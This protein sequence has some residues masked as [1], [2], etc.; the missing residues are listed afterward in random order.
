MI[1]DTHAHIFSWEL[2]GKEDETV[3]KY[4]QAWVKYI[5]CIWYD[6]DSIESTIH[7]AKNHE[8]IHAVIGIHPCD[9]NK[10]YGWI[11]DKIIWLL[12]DTII[13]NPNLIRGI[14]ETWFDYY[15]IDK[16]RFQEEQ[17]IQ[18]DFF[19]AQIALAKKFNFPVIIHNR[20]AKED[21][22]RVLKE[23]DMKN[24]LL[25]CFAEDL[26]FANRC[27]DFSEDCKIS[28]SWIITYNNAKDVQ[29][30]ATNIPLKN[31]IIETDSPYLAPVPYRWKTNEP[32]YITHVL[33]KLIELRSEKPEEVIKTVFENSLDIYWIKK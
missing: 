6:L 22:L 21:T 7:L 15:W 24:F 31:I 28:F 8:S 25:H 19:K 32:A 18:E 29:N 4:L 20:D 2:A 16:D 26:D 14:W 1:F 17:Q 9:A 10:N 27:I 3:K 5:C 13:E 11:Q 33:D 12:E 30:T 23:T